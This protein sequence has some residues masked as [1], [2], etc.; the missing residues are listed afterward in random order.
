MNFLLLCRIGP[1][2]DAAEFV[3]VGVA[4]VRQRGGRGLAAV[5]AAAV[6]QH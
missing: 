5:S 2:V 1:G 6:D 3:D 4:Q